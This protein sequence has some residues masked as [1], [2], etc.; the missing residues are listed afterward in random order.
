MKTYIPLKSKDSNAPRGLLWPSCAILSITQKSQESFPAY[1]LAT[2]QRSWERSGTTSLQ[3]YEQKVAELKEKYEK[4]TAA[5]QAK[6]KPDAVKKG[7]VRPERVRK[8]R[9]KRKMKKKIMMNM[10]VLEQFFS[11]L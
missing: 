3:H 1:P 10:L 7:C 11:C 9:K 5:Y 2:L 4:D 8:R 6:G